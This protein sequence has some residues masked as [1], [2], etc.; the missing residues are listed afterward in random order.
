MRCIISYSASKAG[1]T[2]RSTGLRRCRAS[3]CELSRYKN[4]C[5]RT[6]VSNIREYYSLRPFNLSPVIYGVIS[7]NR[8]KYLTSILFLLLSGIVTAAEIKSYKLNGGITVTIEEAPFN[9]KNHKIENCENS[10]IPCVIDGSYPFGTAFSMPRTYLKKLTFTIKEQTYYLDT[11][12]MYNAWSKRLLKHKDSIRY[13][14]AHCYSKKNCKLRGIFS[15]AAGSYV[16]EWIMYGNTSQRTV[17]T[18][19]NDIMNLFIK[20][21]DPPYYE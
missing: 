17:L 14:G 13:L 4:R 3:S 15:D 20:N 10:E 8:D 11:S 9:P 7:M 18:F 5:Q 21:I 19:T 6:I 16:A 2:M 1:I 12:G